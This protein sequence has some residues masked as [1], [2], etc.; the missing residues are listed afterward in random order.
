MGSYVQFIGAGDQNGD[1]DVDLLARNGRGLMLFK[2]KGNGR[3]GSRTAV[4]GSWGVYNRI[5]SGADLN[6][7]GRLDLV[8]RRTKGAVFILPSSGAGTF[9]MPVG[10]ATNVRSLRS[11]TGAGNL[12]G[13]AAPDLV[14]VKD[15]TLVV[16]PNRGTFDL[17]PPSTPVS[18]FAARTPC[19]TSAT[20]TA[21]APVT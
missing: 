14:G 11:M 12:V 4:P 9:G 15:N 19:S 6:G 5:T 16:V 7:D 21:T 8:A 10:P 1:G 18:S 17:G 2:G 13:D 3:F 20:G